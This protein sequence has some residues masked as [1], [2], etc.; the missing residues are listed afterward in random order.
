MTMTQSRDRETRSVMVAVRQQHVVH[1]YDYSPFCGCFMGGNGVVLPTTVRWPLLSIWAVMRLARSL[2]AFGFCVARPAAPDMNTSG[3]SGD[4][5]EKP[6]VRRRATLSDAGAPRETD[7]D[8]RL[9]QARCG[10]CEAR[11]GEPRRQP[12]SGPGT[13]GRIRMRFAPVAT[14]RKTSQELRCQAASL[15]S[16]WDQAVAS[17]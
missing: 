9:Y 7:G 13:E 15:F 1:T 14:H 5:T 12:A 3:V 6:A 17:S 10:A 4:R 2:Q 11:P 8:A 16:W